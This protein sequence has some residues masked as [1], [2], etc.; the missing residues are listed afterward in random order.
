[1][2]DSYEDLEY[3]NQFSR[4]YYASP[5]TR[6]S[7]H[8]LIHGWLGFGGWYGYGSIVRMGWGWNSDGVHL[9]LSASDGFG[10]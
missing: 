1:M 4:F 10:I 3:A 6:I 8:F 9:G 5:G 7:T 2:T